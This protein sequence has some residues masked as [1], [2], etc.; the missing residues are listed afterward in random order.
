MNRPEE[1]LQRAI[2]ELWLHI[3]RDAVQMQADA[4]GLVGHKRRCVA[5]GM[6]TRSG[7]PDLVFIAPGGQSYFVECKS[8]KGKLSPAQSAFERWCLTTGTPHL[9]C[10]DLDTIRAWWRM[11]GLSKEAYQRV[12]A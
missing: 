10:R 4:T 6:G 5:A 3:G 2:V 8:G 7:W 9:V 12:T 11:H 1:Q